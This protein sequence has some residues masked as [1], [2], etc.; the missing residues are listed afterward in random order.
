MKKTIKKIICLAMCALTLFALAGCSGS[1]NKE[2]DIEKLSGD[3]LAQVQFKDTLTKIDDDM[4]SK[5]YGIVVKSL[6]QR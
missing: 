3:L 4:I 1:E 5:L 2:L 6:M